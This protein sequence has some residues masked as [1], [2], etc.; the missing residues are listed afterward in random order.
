MADFLKA[1]SITA[2]NEGGYAN[3]PADRGGETWKGVARKAHPNWPGWRIVDSYRNRLGFPKSLYGD[4]LLQRMVHSLYKTSYWDI[5]RGDE[6][7]DQAAANMIYDSAVNIGTRPAIKLAQR[8][9]A[10][11][12]TGIMN[13]TTL[14]KLNNR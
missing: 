2:K 11:P 1:Y 8:S 14:N 5:I 6:I 9:L 10:L 4:A 7:K 13:N 3:D 12:E